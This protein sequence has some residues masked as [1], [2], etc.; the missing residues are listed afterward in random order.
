MKSL[1]H[2]IEFS[3]VI[4]AFCSSF[5]VLRVVCGLHVRLLVPWSTRLAQVSGDGHRCFSSE[6]CTGGELMS[7]PRENRFLALIHH[8]EHGIGWVTSTA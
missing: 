1:G 7:S 5:A 4:L 6:C 8:A 2:T 3:Y